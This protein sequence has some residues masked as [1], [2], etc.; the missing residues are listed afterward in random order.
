M[1]FFIAHSAI[2]TADCARVKLVR[3]TNGEASVIDE[4]R[5]HH[6]FGHFRLRG[7]RRDRKRNR[8]QAET[9]QHGDLVV[10]H[11][12]LRHAFGDIGHAGVVLEDHFD[13]LAGDRSAVARL[14][15]LHRGIDL[16]ARRSLR[17]SHRQDQADLHGV[18]RESARG[19]RAKRG[20][21]QE[22]VPTFVFLPNNS[23]ESPRYLLG[24][25]PLGKVQ[26][27]QR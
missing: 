10:D 6:D 7:D 8:R 25:Q 4:C 22:F 18:L 16:L 24:L 26:I 9:G 21:D 20:C 23:L 12:F 27:G 5:G 2:G 15:E 13:L 1:P 17:A 14:V 3:T 11:E 19:D